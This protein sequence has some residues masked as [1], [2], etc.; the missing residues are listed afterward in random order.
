MPWWREIRNKP[1]QERLPV[2]IGFEDRFPAI[3]PRHDMVD[4]SRILVA[5]RSGH[6]GTCLCHL[7]FSTKLLKCSS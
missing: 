3:A 1:E 2:L 4:G 6:A 5:Q 7:H